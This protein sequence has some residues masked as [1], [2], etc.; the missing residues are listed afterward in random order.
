MH[1]PYK[2]NFLIGDF[3]KTILLT[4]IFISVKIITQK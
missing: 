1:F 2:D 4:T 3:S